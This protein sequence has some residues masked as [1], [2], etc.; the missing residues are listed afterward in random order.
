M[1]LYQ[2][3]YVAEV[4]QSGSIT[5]AAKNLFMGQPNLSKAIR[6][7]EGEIGITIFRRTS[8]GVE[9]TEAG[10]QFLIYAKTILSQVDE[11][12]SLYKPQTKQAV[13]LSVS[14]PRA[15]YITVALT[16]YLEQAPKD[17]PLDVHFKETSSMSAITDVANG[18]SLLG[19]IR[20][21]QIHQA[22]YQT[23]IASMKL[24][25]ELLWEFRMCLLMSEDHPLSQCGDI[26]YHLLDGYTEICHGDIQTP[27]LSFSQIQKDAKLQGQ[28]RRIYIYERGSQFNLLQR[29]GGTY[30]WVSP[31]PLS[32]LTESR[33]VMKECPI[34]TAN[35]QD[36]LIYKEDH[37]LSGPEKEFIKLVKGYTNNILPY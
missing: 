18:E 28:K 7:L 3:R 11:L 27:S 4:E 13:K 2:L 10:A 8:K 35:N 21:P 33:L 14:V 26:P 19:I 20:A 6:E 36:L 34:A 17:V 25:W 5:R 1:N 22:Y 29:V 16:D 31:V 32:I 24:R 12:E 23:L 37:T 30:M 9:P 15:T